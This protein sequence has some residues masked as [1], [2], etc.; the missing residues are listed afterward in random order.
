MKSLTGDLQQ[1]PF[2][3]TGTKVAVLGYDAEA[4]AHALAIRN[5]GN[6]VSIGLPFA[7]WSR[8]LADGFAVDHPS[9]VVEGA[10]V[11]V[12]L[13][14]D[15]Q[16]WRA[17]TPYIAPGALVVVGCGFALETSVFEPT[18]A[19]VVLVTGTYDDD[20]SACRIAVHRD[21]NGRA[22]VRAIAYARA[23]FGSNATICTT[24]VA[25]EADRE[26]AVVAERAGSLLAVAASLRP[27]GRRDTAEP[28][29]AA[30]PATFVDAVAAR[31]GQS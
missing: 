21:A 13:V 6:V 7:C 27:T 5:A 29:D 15:E 22:L 25:A 26:L 19:D 23:A 28:V 8:A 18:G 10:E 2:M 30:E 20:C 12:L 3:L 31:R 24:S 11:V 16:V 4:R 14:R 1:G 9:I 17:A